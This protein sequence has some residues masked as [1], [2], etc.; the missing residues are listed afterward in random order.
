M[1]MRLLTMVLISGF[2]HKHNMK[3]TYKQGCV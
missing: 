3:L 1:H 2:K